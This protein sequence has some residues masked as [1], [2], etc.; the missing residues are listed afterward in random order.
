LEKTDIIT[1]GA[2]FI[3]FVVWLVRLEGKV[4]YNEKQ[5]DEL[6]IKHENLDS[7]LVKKLSALETAIARVE[8]Y[9][10]AKTEE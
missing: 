9:L 4:Y 1:L 6:Q 8:G 3:G 2:T 7:E 5:I 10:K